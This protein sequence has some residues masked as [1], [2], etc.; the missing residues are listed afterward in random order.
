MDQKA[1]EL[2]NEIKIEENI[3]ISKKKAKED[4]RK[5]VEAYEAKKA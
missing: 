4:Q 2:E 1:L 3:E 5:K